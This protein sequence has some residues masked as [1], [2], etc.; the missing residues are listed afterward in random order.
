MKH[1][2]EN[3]TR[4]NDKY[5]LAW[6][7]KTKKYCYGLTEN[8]FK[9]HNIT[10]TS[11]NSNDDKKFIKDYDHN[12][13]TFSY[14]A[15]SNHKLNIATDLIN[16]F[17]IYKELF[18]NGIFDHFDIYESHLSKE[19]KEFLD[20]HPDFDIHNI[21]H[22]KN[23]D[24]KKLSDHTDIYVN[25]QDSINRGKKL[26]NQNKRNEMNEIKN[27]YL[28]VKYKEGCN[29]YY[30]NKSTWYE[31]KNNNNGNIVIKH[32]ISNQECNTNINRLELVPFN[33]ILTSYKLEALSLNKKIKELEIFSKEQIDC[34]QNKQ[35]NSENQ[36]SSKNNINNTTKSQ[37]M[38]LNNLIPNFK[39]GKLN[40]RHSI[41]IA[42][43]LNG[44]AFRNPTTNQFVV[45]D[46]NN[47]TIIEVGNMKIDTEFYQIPVKT[48][49][50]GDITII[51]GKF[52][53]VEA[54]NNDGSLKLIN[55][56]SGFR[57]NKLERTNILGIYFYTKIVSMFDFMG[58]INNSIAENINSP[59]GNM[60]FQ[61]PS[62]VKTTPIKKTTVQRTK[63]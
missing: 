50:E 38:N 8:Y 51:D 4:I 48:L 49:S 1:E 55:P 7:Y 13:Y 5:I 32:L 53:I 9:N 27:E 60:N 12:F 3:K 54:V 17:N 26:I 31:V 6:H 44:I 33:N 59:F 15:S 40:S 28:I 63:K 16:N 58:N 37:E 2:I 56:T 47:K 46:K 11:L 34:I 20:I 10:M 43:S 24:Y 52:F 35:L 45:Y 41:N 42:Y 21:Y 62:T 36:N 14:I 39:F 22:T 61:Q 57:A 18:P 30:I 29:Y 23:N 25:L 19:I